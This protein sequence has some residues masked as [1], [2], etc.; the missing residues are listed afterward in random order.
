MR[1]RLLQEWRSLRLRTRRHIPATFPA[2]RFHNGVAGT[3]NAARLMAFMESTETNYK[4]ERWL[5][6]ILSLL[7]VLP[8]VVR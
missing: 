3:S 5:A 1:K 8:F 6:V 7:F 2:R 4:L